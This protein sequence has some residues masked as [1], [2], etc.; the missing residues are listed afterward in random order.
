MVCW[1]G[2][3]GVRYTRPNE[4]TT[5]HNNSHDRRE[6]VSASQAIPIKLGIDVHADF[7]VVVRQ[8]D[9]QHPQPPQKFTATEFLD[10]ARRQCT[11]AVA[12]HS[13][14]EA[15]AFGYGLHRRL[16]ELGVHN[17]VVAPQRLDERHPGVKTDQT[18][19]R[20]LVLKLDQYV[21]TTTRWPWSGCPRLPRNRVAPWPGNGNSSVTNGGGWRRR[22]GVCC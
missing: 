11:L 15:G 2:E 10:W 1:S 14:D 13:C 8:V 21:A 9:G 17:L 22:G 4:H 16:T 6:Q 7:Y 20:A 5:Q 12:V 3:R 19:A 18:D